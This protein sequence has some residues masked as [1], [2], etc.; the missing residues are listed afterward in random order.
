MSPAS[1]RA[2]PAPT[3][4]APVT[5]LVE[6]QLGEN[7]GAAAR[8]MWNFGLSELRLVG[9][10]D[11]W[12]N[13]QAVAMASGAGRVLDAA[14]V[15]GSTAE[16]VADLHFVYATTARPREM[17]KTVMTP[18]RA[19]AH[20]RAL[21]AGGSRVGVLYGRERTGLENADV[22]RANAVVTVPVNPA[23]PSL[24]LAQCVLLMAYEWRRQEATEG[25]G[26]AEVAPGG[27]WQPAQA[28][29]VA[30]MLDHLVGELEAARF[31]WPEAKRPAMEANLRNLLHRAPL[32]EQDVRTLWGVVRA[33]A[34]GPKRRG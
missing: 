33:L 26:P 3:G 4:P 10:R 34:E 32:T 25:S 7:I 13:P 9:P 8:A 31:F 30:R 2:R 5:I 20:A 28:G 18:E 14:R 6:P 1:T 12:P 29:E 19:M 16:A 22:V 21:I 11:G 23:F 15:H 17:A 27:R 24:N